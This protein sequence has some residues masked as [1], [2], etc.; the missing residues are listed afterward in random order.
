MP[1]KSGEPEVA[2]DHTLGFGGK[3]Q[4]DREGIKKM[5]W[6]WAGAHQFDGLLPWGCGWGGMSPSLRL[7]GL[8]RL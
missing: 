3:S 7:A 6:P 5:K 2:C 1:F 4:G 8:L